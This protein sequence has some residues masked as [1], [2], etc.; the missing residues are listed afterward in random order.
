MINTNKEK[1][2]GFTVSEKRK[3]VWAAELEMVKVFIGIC[4]KYGFKYF[5]VSGTLLGAVRHK[6]F[7][8]WDDDI[9]LTMPREDYEKFLSVAQNELPSYMFLQCNKTEKEYPTGHAQIR[10]SKTTCLRIGELERLKKGCN[11]GIFIDIFPYD[12]IPDNIKERNK[13]AERIK[14]IR[15][16]CA[17]IIYP[18]SDSR[19]KRVIKKFAA[20]CLRVFTP[21]EKYIEMINTLSKKTAV[22]KTECVGLTSFAP[23]CGSAIWRKEVFDEYVLCD[24][25]DIKIR[26]PTLFDE[27]LTVEFGSDYMTLPENPQESAHGQCY[28]DTEKPYSEYSKLPLSELRNICCDCKL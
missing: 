1:I 22:G 28:F 14:S 6:G 24:F 17:R 20:I 5:A 25:E 8:P 26:I 11:Y 27:E 23:G 2:C 12:G 18:F 21:I 19:L 16:R 7:I 9:D 15:E 10:N 13:Q 3:K 4:D